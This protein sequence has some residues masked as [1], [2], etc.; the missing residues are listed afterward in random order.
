MPLITPEIRDRI[1]PCVVAEAARLRCEVI[2]IGG[3]ED[4]I[5]VL[6][7]TAPTA[8][9]A[10]VVKRFKGVSS[11]LVRTEIEDLFKWQGSY[12]AFSINERNIPMVSRYILR[13]EEHHRTGRINATLERTW[14]D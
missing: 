11:R 6:I 5:H 12:G 10:D 7:H 13:Q 4:H 2:A 9:V 1:Y 14:A 3:I 8:A